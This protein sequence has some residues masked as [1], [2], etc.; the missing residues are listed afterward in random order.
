MSVENTRKQFRLVIHNNSGSKSGGVPMLSLGFGMLFLSFCK[1]YSTAFASQ[2]FA[3][4]C[5]MSMSREKLTSLVLHICLNDK[6][7]VYED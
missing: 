7:C 3:L 2:G 4:S 1:I 5:N 6:A